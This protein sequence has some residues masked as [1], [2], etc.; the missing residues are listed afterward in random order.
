MSDLVA[1]VI[2]VSH[3]P[4]LANNWSIRQDRTVND[5]IEVTRAL[6]KRGVNPK[7][8]KLLLSAKGNLP[9]DVAG[10]APHPAQLQILQRFI[11]EEIFA[12]P[13]LGDRFLFFCSG[14]GVAAKDRQDTLL[15]LSDSGVNQ[16]TH[17]FKWLALEELR[18]QFQGMPQFSEQI[19]CVNACRTPQ[20]WAMVGNYNKA[21]VQIQMFNRPKKAVSQTKILSARELA[22]AP[23]Q[24]LK[25]G[26]SNGFA[27]AVVDCIKSG[28]WPPRAGE[29]SGRIKQAWKSTDATEPPTSST[30]L[31]KRLVNAR[32]DLD[33]GPQ[34]LLAAKKLAD[35]SE[36]KDR[37]T[38][39][40]L[41]RSTVVDLHACDT[42]R[43]D[44]LVQRLSQTFFKPPTVIGGIRRV[45]R[46]PSREDST[47]RRTRTL[48]GRLA[49]CLTDN[50]E[51]TDPNAI[52][53]E[54]AAVRKGMRVAYVQI[55]GPCDADLDRDLIGNMLTFW[56]EIIHASTTRTPSVNT[57]PLLLIGHEDP[58]PT[59]G[60]SP[61]D[62]TMFYRE[63]SLDEEDP[64]RL[65]RVRGFEIYDW[66][67]P[68]IPK[69]DPQRADVETELSR[70]LGVA[71]VDDIH[72]RM[73]QIV[74]VVSELAK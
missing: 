47:D 44:F 40:T 24:D 19:F 2:G 69:D 9:N 38:D 49:Y 7:K 22:S 4:G 41:W 62:T 54:L 28:E 50:S 16:N 15:I 74:D 70:A 36:W 67:A 66:L 10:V 60:P 20:E 39:P 29:W 63:E 37:Q 42:D 8:I 13:F 48:R 23:V 73:K 71:L 12:E 1:L 21:Y 27:S 6:V 68:I 53:K 26:F 11:G 59:E 56:Q 58:E 34:S 72:A 65:R 35:A 51:Q 18:L 57:L 32:H 33:R 52:A 43:L 14:H 55:S 3:Y 30:P 64:R 5:A 25:D 46:W 61:I 31:F 45:Q 17:F